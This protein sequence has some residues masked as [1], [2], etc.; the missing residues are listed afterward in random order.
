[1]AINSLL[2]SNIWQRCCTYCLQVSYCT[3]Q[4]KQLDL[5]TG[6]KRNIRILFLAAIIVAVSSCGNNNTDSK[7]IAKQLNAPKFD[8]TDQL[9]D[10]KFAINAADENL[11]ETK[12]GALA[13]TYS[14]SGE[15]KKLGK[16]MVDDHDKANAV[17]QSI[18]SKNNINIPENLS[19]DSYKKYTTLEKKTGIEFDKAYVDMML[20]DHKDLIATFKTEADSGNNES[21]KLWA[22]Q[23]LPVIEQ[24]LQ[25]VQQVLDSMNLVPAYNK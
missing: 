2:L 11:L 19:D 3:T 5:F 9:N 24:H 7:T 13:Q 1:M 18:V 21:L 6:M 15:I 17:L 22:R 23:Q 4:I 20:A 14:P 16:Q 10:T 25:L 12:S 8:S